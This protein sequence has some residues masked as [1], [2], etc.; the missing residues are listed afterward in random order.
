[1]K[2]YFRMDMPNTLAKSES[3][4]EEQKALGKIGVIRNKMLGE[5][6]EEDR[7]SVV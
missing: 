3:E 6:N 4:V 5:F 1:M 7:K 2:Q